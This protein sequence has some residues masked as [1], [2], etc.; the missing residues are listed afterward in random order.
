M[1]QLATVRTTTART[2]TAPTGQEGSMRI[3][4]RRNHRERLKTEGKE[5]QA[6]RRRRTKR[7]QSNT[8]KK[9]EEKTEKRRRQRRR[10]M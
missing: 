8:K 3:F 10:C 9:E 5:D 6:T 2:R 4:S 7:R 1:T